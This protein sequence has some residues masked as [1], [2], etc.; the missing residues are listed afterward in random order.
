MIEG[1][2]FRQEL[3]ILLFT[4][5]FRPALEP[6]QP[7]VQWVTGALS[8]GLRQPGRET[9]HSPSSTP[10]VKNVWSYTSTPPTRLHGVVTS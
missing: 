2:E 3:G 1:Y 8:L 5:A 10:E 4:T 7:P 6:T 9:D